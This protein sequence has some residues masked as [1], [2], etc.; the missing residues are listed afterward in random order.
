MSKSAAFW[1]MMLCT[2]CWLHFQG[3]RVSRNVGT[4]V[5]NYV[6]AHPRSLL[7]QSWVLWE[8]QFSYWNCSDMFLVL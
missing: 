5:P 4:S 7:Y 2:T 1:D 6:V 3:R 8:F